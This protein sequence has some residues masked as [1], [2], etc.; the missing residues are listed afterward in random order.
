MEADGALKKGRP[1]AGN[2]CEQYD[3]SKLEAILPLCEIPPFANEMELHP[4]FQQPE[5]Y[6][7]CKSHNMEIIGFCPLGSPNRPERDRTEGDISD[8]KMEIIQELALQY[9]CSPQ[10]IC[11]KWAVTRG[12]TPIPFSGNPINIAA[13]LAAAQEKL[14]E[15]DMARIALADRNCRLVK[16]QVFLWQGA[17]DWREL[18]DLDGHLAHWIY[19]ENRWIKENVS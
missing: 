1:R 6:S 13:N 19:D 4:S 2:C 3:D 11:I 12:H 17:D 10:E 18:W 16:G 14:S 8:I 15:E 7:Y 9:H 5:L